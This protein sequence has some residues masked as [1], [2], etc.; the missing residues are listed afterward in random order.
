MTSYYDTAL[1]QL[2]EW[3]DERRYEEMMEKENRDYEAEML[4]EQLIADQKWFVYRYRNGI[5][6][7]IYYTI[8]E[9]YYC[10]EQYMWRAYCYLRNLWSRM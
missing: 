9:T 3:E 2:A 7:Y 5:E 4:E 8:Y 10:V 6:N 1:D